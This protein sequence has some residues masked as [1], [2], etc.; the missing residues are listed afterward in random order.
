MPIYASLPREVKYEQ[1]YSECARSLNKAEASMWMECIVEHTRLLR[2][3]L[4]YE[5]ALTIEKENVGYYSGYCAHDVADRIMELYDCEH[6]FFGRSHP[7]AEEAFRM[8]QEL[9]E[10]LRREAEA[11]LANGMV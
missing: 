10:R 6:P 3:E 9:G 5:E 8:G 1:K 11:R 4:S 7:T 2:P